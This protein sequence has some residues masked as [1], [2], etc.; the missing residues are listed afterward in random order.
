[1]PAS[2]QAA[3][4]IENITENSHH[5]GIVPEQY[6]QNR[7]LRDFFTVL[8]TNQL[9]SSG[10]RFV[11]TIEAKKYPISATQ[12]HPEKNNFE[13]GSIGRFGFDAIPHSANAVA[14]SQY[15]ANNF[16]AR[17]RLSSHRFIPAGSEATE[18][19]YNDVPQKDP[20][21]YFSQVYLWRNHHDDDS[22]ARAAQALE[23]EESGSPASMMV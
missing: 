12:W 3:L 1:M 6:K 14:L 13:W 16:V 21:G 22:S 18:L 8:S 5:S 20:N 23:E 7:R 17:A 2:L 19:I 10:R 15:M 11:S 9:G 4:E